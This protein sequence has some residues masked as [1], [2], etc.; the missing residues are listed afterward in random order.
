M[1]VISTSSLAQP[2]SVTTD[3]ASARDAGD[4]LRYGSMT[5]SSRSG[6]IASAVR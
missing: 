6:P 1:A 4:E 3:S 2:S 5:A